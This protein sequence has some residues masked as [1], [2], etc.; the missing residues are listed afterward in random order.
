MFAQQLEA[1]ALL[2]QIS[3]VFPGQQLS[4][5]LGSDVVQL[6]VLEDGF[7]PEAKGIGRNECLRLVSDTEVIV[8]PNPRVSHDTGMSYEPSK[9]LKVLPSYADYTAGMKQV[10]KMFENGTCLVDNLLP[11]P[12]MFTAWMHPK[13]LSSINGWD[14]NCSSD[15]NCSLYSFSPSSTHVE[16][17]RCHR[18]RFLESVQGYSAIVK[19]YSSEIIPLG[20]IG[21]YQ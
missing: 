21:K 16:I 14:N 5:R 11:C 19:L 8:T 2:E 6:L 15:P 3:I 18:N 10:E 9:P 4:L 1:G 7:C 13:T 17:R 12:P 20:C